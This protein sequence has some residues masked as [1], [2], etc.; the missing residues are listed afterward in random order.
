MRISLETVPTPYLEDLIAPLKKSFGEHFFSPSSI[1][2]AHLEDDTS[3]EDSESAKHFI[4]D[5]Y[6]PLIPVELRKPSEFVER[7]LKK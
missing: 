4:P 2:Y 6:D 7:F 3:Y 1:P 5:S